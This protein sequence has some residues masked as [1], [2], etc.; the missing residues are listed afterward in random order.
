[1][2]NISVLSKIS[3]FF[4]GLHISISSDIHGTISRA[5]PLHSYDVDKL[6]RQALALIAKSNEAPRTGDMISW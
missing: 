2:A 4:R 6:T 1:M 3:K 5:G